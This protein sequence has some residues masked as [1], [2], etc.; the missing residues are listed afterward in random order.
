MNPCQP[1]RKV[2]ARFQCRRRDSQGRSNECNFQLDRQKS[3][4]LKCVCSEAQRSYES[5]HS[6]LL[7]RLSHGR[8]AGV[9]PSVARHR[10]GAQSTAAPTSVPLLPQ[11]RAWLNTGPAECWSHL[12]TVDESPVI[13]YL[14][15]IPAVTPNA[16][17][18]TAIQHVVPASAVTHTSPAPVIE[19]VA[20]T[21]DA[22]FDE[23]SRASEHMAPAPADT[24]AG[25]S[26]SDLI[27]GTGTC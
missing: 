10:G 8:G 2:S 19:H 17:P 16:A 1:H 7:M 13:K 23:T 25:T 6:F 5:C 22:T 14:A 4:S 24:F 21:L 27:R 20:P 18:E 3:F 11:A 12:Q 26:S 15:L 9:R